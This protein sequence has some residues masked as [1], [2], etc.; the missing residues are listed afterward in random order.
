MTTIH[1]G[2]AVNGSGAVG[3]GS[4][5]KA[6]AAPGQIAPTQTQAQPG[7]AAP[8][9]EVA[10][11]PTAQLLANL[12]QQIAGTPD[13]NQSRVDSIRQALSNGSYQVD[14]RRVADGLLAAQ[15]FDAQATKASG[16]LVQ[17]TGAKAFAATAQLGSDRSE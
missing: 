13:I 15:K 6:Q 9:P 7:G 2:V 17:S 3:S 4:T 1:H 8:S 12:E 10:I 11:T 14:S 16:S 5:D